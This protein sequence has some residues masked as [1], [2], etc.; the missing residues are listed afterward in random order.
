MAYFIWYL[1]NLLCVMVLTFIYSSI[2]WHYWHCY[3]VVWRV[4]V[5]AGIVCVLSLFEG[6]PMLAD[7]KY[8]IFW[9]CVWPRWLAQYWYLCYLWPTAAGSGIVTLFVAIVL[10]WKCYCPIVYL[11]VTLPN[12]III[13][14]VNSGNGNV[15]WW[16]ILVKSNRPDEGPAW[17]CYPV[18]DLIYLTTNNDMVLQAG[19]DV[20]ITTDGDGIGNLIS[21]RY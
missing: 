20:T 15:M 17:H 5:G 9:H 2:L 14:Y 18:P 10:L 12:V 8:L 4:C 6:T 7:N 19:D 21:A 16:N 13:C 1:Y 11:G 3:C